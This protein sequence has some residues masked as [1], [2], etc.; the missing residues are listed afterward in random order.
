MKYVMFM[1]QLGKSADGM[2]HF[3]PIIFPNNLVHIMI[4]DSMTA[5]GAPLEGY[6][7]VSGGEISPLDMKCFGES[8]TLKMRSDPERDSRF[9]L[10]GDYGVCYE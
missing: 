2:K 5:K 8:S 10:M 6:R 9:C 4:A 7:P 3:V 1:K